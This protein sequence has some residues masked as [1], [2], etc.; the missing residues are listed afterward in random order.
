MLDDH[1]MMVPHGPDARAA[2]RDLITSLK[3]A[4]PLAPITVVPPSTYAG[5]STRRGLARAGGLVNVRFLPLARVAELLGAPSLARAGLDPRSR[6]VTAAAVRRALRSHEGVFTEVASHPATEQAIHSALLELRGV[7]DDDL[8]ALAATSARARAVVELVRDALDHASGTYDE[9]DLALAAATTVERAETDGNL[10]V[11]LADLGTVVLYLL[12]RLSPGERTLVGALARRGRLAAV[13]GLTGDDQAD[14]PVRDLAAWLGGEGRPTPGRP[15][16]GA[17]HL[18]VLP[19]PTEEVR[20]VVRDALSRMEAGTPLHR[21]AVVS[22]V[23][24]PYPAALRDELRGAGIPHHLA[25]PATLANSVAGRTLLGGLDLPGDDFARHDV[26]AW[27]AAAPILETPAGTE[28]PT[29]EWDAISR[30]AGVVRSPQQWHARLGGHASRLRARRDDDLGDPDA[31]PDDVE[32]RYATRLDHTDR[33]HGF[34]TELCSFVG[35][36]PRGSWTERAEWCHT[37]L[38]R[39]LGSGRHPDWPA[40]DV[41]DLERVRELLSALSALDSIDDPPDDTT[42]RQTL[43]D[44]L[45]VTSGRKGHL[46]DGLFVGGVHDLAGTD[47]DV[48]YVLGMVEGQFPPRRGDDPILTD[49]E[50]AAVEGVPERGTIAD[51]RRAY[52]SALASATTRVLTTHRQDPRAQQERH[53]AVWFLEAASVRAER[54]LQAEDLCHSVPGVTC[55][56]SAPAALAHAPAAASPREHDLIELQAWKRADADPATHPT[57]TSRP[58]LARGF[59]CVTARAGPD[60]SPF[61]GFVGNVGPLLSSAERP[62]SPTAL[63]DWATCPFRHFLRRVLR[64]AARDDPQDIEDLSAADRGSL[65]HRILERAIGEMIGD[66]GP[67]TPW[68]DARRRRVLEIA[69]DEFAEYESRGR[70]GH[71]LLWRRQQQVIR[72]ELDRILDEDERIRAERRLTPLAVEEAFGRRGAEPVTVTLRPGVEVQIQGVADRLDGN[73]TEIAVYD[74][75]TGSD[76]GYTDLERDYVA[77][78]RRLQLPAYALAARARYPDRAVS[79][80]Y[81][82][83]SERAG[84]KF[85]PS[86]GGHFGPDEEARFQEVLGHIVTGVEAGLYPANP[87][88]EQNDTYEHC[89]YCD[90]DPV[91]SADR[92]DAW[93]RVASHEALESY[94]ALARTEPDH[95]QR[96]GSEA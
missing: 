26:L 9:H 15:P 82:F 1:L 50:R 77:A 58:R 66:M 79:A 76:G 2:L 14:A 5:L 62:L 69:E 71:P 61:T 44:T 31:I 86:D 48:V 21:M 88:P 51:E 18:V 45:N 91:C 27:L 28:I 57:V 19:D 94:R 70:T 85:R 60:P 41:D 83:V 33:L 56:P 53:P 49:D 63:Q 38:D 8:D 23:D 65:V 40:E 13:L 84:F 3:K 4:D 25:A 64:L 7:S 52:L 74:Y 36:R 34:M 93:E 11:D 43:E 17:E 90:F 59:E 32:A 10:D 47:F 24:D 6:A 80:R 75:K 67:D 87:G 20:H 16:A 54:E 73:D 81:W 37:F 29:A 22:R 95:D 92:L 35:Q 72:R 55:V 39:Y 46:A 30:E 89:R 68:T 96:P 12:E 42:F 78:G